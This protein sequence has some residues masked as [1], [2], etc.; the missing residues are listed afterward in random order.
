MCGYKTGTIWCT[1]YTRNYRGIYAL[2]VQE[3][4]EPDQECKAPLPS[5]PPT[6]TP[7]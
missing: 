7:K 1:V 6:P 4:T 3:T 2:P 5:P